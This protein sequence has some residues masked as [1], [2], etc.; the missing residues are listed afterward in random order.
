[1]NSYENI[2]SSFFPLSTFCHLCTF[3]IIYLPQ[4]HSRRNVS[5]LENNF[6]LGKHPF[7]QMIK[8][9]CIT[10]GKTQI[11]KR[12]GQDNIIF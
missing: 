9:V 12:Q 4:E 7:I 2:E 11:F 5:I 1:M 3:N 10:L 8:E 6:S